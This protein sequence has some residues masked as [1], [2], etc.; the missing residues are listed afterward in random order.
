[1]ATDIWS[2]GCIIYKLLTGSVPFTG[3]NSFL[4]FQKILN[5]ELDY[6][7]YLTPEAKSLIDSMLVINPKDRLGAPGSTNGMEALKSHPFF[8]G[9]DF[10]NPKSLSVGES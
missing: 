3:T 2:V 10:T 8:K 4:V 9:I 5:R 1:M 7:E 6:P